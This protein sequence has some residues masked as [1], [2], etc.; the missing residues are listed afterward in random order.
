MVLLAIEMN[1]EKPVRMTVACERAVFCPDFL[2]GVLVASGATQDSL[3]LRFQPRIVL[4]EFW[5]IRHR[6]KVVTSDMY[7][8]AK[9]MGNSLIIR[10][11]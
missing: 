9:C 10:K 7:R 11:L 6:R 1:S 5:G 2:E 8:K 4:N 3:S